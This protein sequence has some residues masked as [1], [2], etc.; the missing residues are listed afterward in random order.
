MD[1]EQ[2]AP[3][4]SHGAGPPSPDNTGSVHDRSRG[5]SGSVTPRDQER[6][7]W[8]VRTRLT[9][10]ALP[11]GAVTFG[12]FLAMDALVATDLPQVEPVRQIELV[13]ITPSDELEQPR[14][15][16]RQPPQRIDAAMQPP[17]PLA[18]TAR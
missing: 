6:P 9:L 15:A 17:P 14:R 10:A 16:K 3:P 13:K 2:T 12:L 11:A 18:L 1:H 7:R 4:G 8:A 5:G